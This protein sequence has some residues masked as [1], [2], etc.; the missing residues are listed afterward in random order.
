MKLQA[1]VARLAKTEFL[2]FFVNRMVAVPTTADATNDD[3]TF[4]PND[5]SDCISCLS[6]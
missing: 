1:R 4:F 3:N 5:L 6:F 2:L